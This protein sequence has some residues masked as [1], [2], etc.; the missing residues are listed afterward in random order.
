[1]LLLSLYLWINQGATIF[2][3]NVCIVFLLSLKWQLYGLWAATLLQALWL[4]QLP[5][6]EYAV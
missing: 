5:D 3:F 4:M 1:M 2:I 6:L